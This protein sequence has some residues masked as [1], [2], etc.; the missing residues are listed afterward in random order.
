VQIPRG[1]LLGAVC[2]AGAAGAADEPRK[3]DV[4][5]YTNEDL[6]RV[7]PLRDQTGGGMTAPS[8]APASA[9]AKDDG[10]GRARAEAYWRG[11]ADR[12]QA[13][14]EPLRDRA[15]QLREKIDERRRKPGV[16]PFS[17]PQ[18]ESMQRRL[19]AMEARIREA[20]DRLHER[21]RRAGAWPSWL[22]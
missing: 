7:S 13:R 5:V 17:D 8:P 1:I 21:A 22:R 19:A 15:A 20:E 18:I 12:L 11:E 3:K 16:R 2:C 9:A 14:L 10:P 4:P 6:A